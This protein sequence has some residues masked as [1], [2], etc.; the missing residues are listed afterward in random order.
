MSNQTEEEYEI[1]FFKLIQ[2]IQLLFTQKY[3]LVTRK[4]DGLYYSRPPAH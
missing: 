1:R 3:K 2:Y 4:N